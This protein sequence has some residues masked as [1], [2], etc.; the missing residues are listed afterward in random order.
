MN[1]PR[2]TYVT[3]ST[4]MWD[5]INE[6]P[7]ILLLLEHFD[8]DFKVGE[9]DVAQLCS[10]HNLPPTLFL[11][12]ANLYNGF[13]PDRKGLQK[14]EEIPR[15][16]SFLTNSHSYYKFDKYPEIIGYI[17]QLLEKTSDSRVKLIEDFFKIYFNEVVE[18][19]D[20]E[21]KVAFPYFLSLS[22][23]KILDNPSVEHFSAMQYK[24]HHTDI[25]TKLADLKSLLIKHISLEGELPLRR[26]LIFAL[27]ELEYDLA[28][29]ASIEDTIL[30]PWADKIER[31]WKN[32]K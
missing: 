8:I 20:Y 18:H 10:Q 28:I 23:H 11:S 15:I 5:L 13:V 7:R 21:D 12:I 17:A 25:E 2:R 14:S 6:N 4:N 29:H 3:P 24:V 1:H 19:L 31:E 27:Q 22:Q 26:R 32:L 16:I 9:C 30:L